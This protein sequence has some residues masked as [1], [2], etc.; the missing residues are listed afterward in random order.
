MVLSDSVEPSGN[1]VM[2]LVLERL[3]ALTGRDEF[4]EAA[5]KALFS[6]AARIRR[7]GLE[8]AGWL[9]GALLAV[10]PRYELVIAGSS[11]APSTR[12]LVEVWNGL[13]APWTVGARVD[14]EG[15]GGELVN[16][17]PPSAGKRD[18]RGTALAYVCVRGACQAPTSDAS[19]LRTALLSGWKR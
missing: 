7:Q 14:A 4:F 10:G 12:S 11:E 9:D 2:I 3:A 6:Q 19:R 16:W 1:A 8:M 5:Q 18:R 15:P 17:M 13:S